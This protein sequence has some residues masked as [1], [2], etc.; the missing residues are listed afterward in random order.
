MKALSPCCPLRGDGSSWLPIDT[1]PRD[2]TLID[3]L[4]D[5][6]TAEIDYG[7]RKPVSMAEFY[8]PGSTRRS[9]PTEPLIER[10]EFSNGH[11]R[12]VTDDGTRLYACD[13]AI[14]LTHWRAA[15]PSPAG[16]LRAGLN[17]SSPNPETHHD[18]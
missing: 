6:Q 14:T 5:P 9:N 13:M 1:A 16:P 18:R 4:F 2:G 11:F 17:D 15:T 10:V 7:G 12:P 3:V 8:A